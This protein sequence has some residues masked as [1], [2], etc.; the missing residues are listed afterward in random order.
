MLSSFLAGKPRPE[1]GGLPKCS[2]ARP[3]NPEERRPVITRSLIF[4]SPPWERIE[5]RG[6][7]P[8]RKFPLLHFLLPPGEENRG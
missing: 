8:F 2:D 4:L 5:V 7:D 6:K 1:G 3:P